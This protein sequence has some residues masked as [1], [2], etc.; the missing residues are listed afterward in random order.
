MGY[1]NDK[2]SMFDEMPEH[3]SNAIVQEISEQLFDNWILGHLDE[4]M[5]IADYEMAS[6]SSDTAVREK[7]N[8]YWD[9][10]PGEEH[11]LDV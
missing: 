11:Y 3:I 7:F 4:G 2:P 6:M 1:Q 9:V 10:Q 5:F 8:T